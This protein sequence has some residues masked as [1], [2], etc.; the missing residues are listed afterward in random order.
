[1]RILKT[2][3]LKQVAHWAR[4]R[5][6]P[7]SIRPGPG[8]RAQEREEVTAAH[9]QW[10]EAS[11]GHGGQDARGFAA[12]TRTAL[13]SGTFKR[14][15]CRID[16]PPSWTVWRCGACG[17]QKEVFH[18]GRVTT[19]QLRVEETL[20]SLHT[21]G[22][23]HIQNHVTQGSALWAG[24]VFP[25]SAVGTNSFLFSFWVFKGALH[26]LSPE[27]LPGEPLRHTQL[28]CCWNSPDSK[29][30]LRSGYTWPPRPPEHL[31]LHVLC[32]EPL[33]LL[34]SVASRSVFYLLY[35]IYLLLTQ[36]IIIV[37]LLLL[38]PQVLS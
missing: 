4:Y 27:T 11:L 2:A 26:I 12:Q 19:E 32:P 23:G 14:R 5:G 10:S 8:P 18:R 25:T 7:A 1:M 9:M 29:S 38:S 34:W 31:V 37:Y 28:T 6:L 30:S 22:E 20:I 35:S 15:P 36:L 33:Y 16:V 17:P 21:R 3:T 24:F 13:K